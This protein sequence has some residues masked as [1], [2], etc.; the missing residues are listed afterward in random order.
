MDFFQQLEADLDDPSQGHWAQIARSTAMHTVALFAE[1][2]S[3]QGKA[4][5]LA[6]TGTLVVVDDAHYIL[7]A[8]HVWK[9]ILAHANKMGI[10]LRDGIDHACYFDRTTIIPSGPPNPD[11]WNEWGPDLVFLRIPEVRVKDIEA[12]RVF[13]RLTTE[14]SWNKGPHVEVHMLL[15]TPHFLGKFSQNYAAVQLRGIWV[16]KPISKKHGDFDYLDV[17]AKEE[18]LQEAKSF[19]GMSGGG[20]WRVR[21]YQDSTSGKI[22][23]EATLKGVAF[24]ELQVDNGSAVI[25]C[26]G[27]KTIFFA[28][29]KAT[30]N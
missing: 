15:G 4:V 13:Y 24:Y 30:A 12:F 22:D 7:T 11:Q 21:I 19:G 27:A 10:S 20:L 29:P 8:A 14:E 5:S 6:G 25:R 18:L 2:N 17:E 16:N 23:S 1:S 28:T 9:E 3:V 26:H